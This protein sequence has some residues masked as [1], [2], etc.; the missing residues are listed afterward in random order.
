MGRYPTEESKDM[1]F[2]KHNKTVEKFA[3]DNA[4]YALKLKK[5]FELYP[6]YTIDTDNLRL[7]DVA[8][9]IIEF[10]V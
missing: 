4:N 5:D 1:F 6:V 7:E 9:K 3:D 10:T 2:K 8:Q